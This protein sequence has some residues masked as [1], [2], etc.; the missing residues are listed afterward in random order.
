[1]ASRLDPAGISSVAP[2]DYESDREA[3]QAG[4]WIKPD[5]SIALRLSGVQAGLILN[6]IIGGRHQI[7]VNPHFTAQSLNPVSSRMATRDQ[8]FPLTGPGFPSSR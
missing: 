7:L 3:G 5:E 4:R 6:V 2:K 8:P 1:L